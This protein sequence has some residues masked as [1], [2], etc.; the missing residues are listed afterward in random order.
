ML[1]RSVSCRRNNDGNKLLQALAAALKRNC[2]EYDYLARMGGD[3]FVILAPG[4]DRAELKERIIAPAAS[5]EYEAG[6][7]AVAISVGSAVYPI[8]GETA[9]HLLTEADHRMYR[10]KREKRASSGRQ[11]PLAHAEAAHT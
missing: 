8:D 11:I 3:E 6:H 1:F 9:E 4:A 7:T 10:N 5:V 2:R